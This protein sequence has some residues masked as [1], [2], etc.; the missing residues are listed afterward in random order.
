M[1]KTRISSLTVRSKKDFCSEFYYP[2]EILTEN[3]GN[4]K[5]LSLSNSR[6]CLSEA[7]AKVKS[8]DN[9]EYGK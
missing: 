4:V 2:D 8:V 6:V 3:E 9:A 1:N 7:N 5:V